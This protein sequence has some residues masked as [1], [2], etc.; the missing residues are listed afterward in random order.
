[1]FEPN[2][3]EKAR[4]LLTLAFNMARLKAA[5]IFNLVLYLQII[6]QFWITLGT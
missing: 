6:F 5:S 2:T 3:P 4:K 1:M